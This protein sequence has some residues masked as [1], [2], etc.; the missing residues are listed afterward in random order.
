MATDDQ[1]D[2]TYAD[3]GAHAAAES[4]ESEQ[5]NTEPLV[6]DWGAPTPEEVQ[7]LLKQPP[8]QLARLTQ[9]HP[10][11]TEFIRVGLDA[12]RTA[13]TEERS[14]NE[15]FAD[16]YYALNDKIVDGLLKRLEQS[17]V[18][19]EEASRIYESL[20]RLQ[21]RNGQKT[22]EFLRASDK[23]GN[24]VLLATGILL[25]SALA[26]VTFYFRQRPSGS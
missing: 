6:V 21:D 8:E 14:S 9:K 20:D 1:A 3:T 12:V 24:K 11:L 4:G 5:G 16:S 18:S 10:Q 2:D 25:T 13:G 22:T 17:G 19:E 26:A 15:H 23:T 7:E